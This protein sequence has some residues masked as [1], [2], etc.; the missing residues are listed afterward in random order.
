M[1]ELR[2]STEVIVRVGPFPDVGDGFTPQT[3]IALSGNEAELLKAASVEVDISGNTWAAIAGCRGWYD[4]TLTASHT[5]T[6]GTLT[7]VV[8]DDSDCLP[9]FRDFMVVTAN[10]WDSKYSTD[11][12][13]VDLVQI[14][15]A[16]VAGN[17]ATLTLKQLDITNS[18][19][20]AFIAKGTGGNGHGMDIAGNGT[21]E[22]ITVAAGATGIGL[23]IAGGSTSGN[24]I[25]VS[26][27]DGD[28][29]QLVAGGNNAGLNVDGSG[30]RPGIQATG[31]A[32]GTG[33]EVNGGSTGGCGII[34]KATGTAYHG[35][36]GTGSGSGDGISSK[37]GGTG[38]GLQAT[39]GVT[40]GAGIYANAQA[41]ND[42]GMEL[43]KHGTGKDLDADTIAADT[44]AILA[45]T[46]TTGVV[47][48]TDSMSAAALKADAVT[49]IW[50]SPMSDMDAGAPSVT[51]TVK[52]A[53][54]WLYSAFRNKTETTAD[55]IALFK[56][57]A[58]T[59]LAESTIS[60]DGTTF[61][62]GEWRAAD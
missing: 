11:E 37:G 50:A 36:Y 49:E 27:T 24:G 2:Q 1:Q 60:D 13:N 59:K 4:L 3:D 29:M 16:S 8:Q 28:G 53:I 42:A 18:A 30:T 17:A 26:A 45:D 46:G 10:W 12:L 47:L 9:V 35:L 15:G 23:N 33:L 22:G 58:S 55:E 20:T 25:T 5:D 38:H 40:S 52:T 7:V 14:G 57:D 43:V 56:D 34:A 21:G 61:S 32:T 48:A 41:N 19:G 51:A 31:G 6:L 44:A 62:K 54:N 39:G